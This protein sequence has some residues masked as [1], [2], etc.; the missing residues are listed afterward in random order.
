MEHESI[1]RAIYDQVGLKRERDRDQKVETISRGDSGE[2][3]KELA[4]CTR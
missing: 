4:T 1:D 3:S 2:V